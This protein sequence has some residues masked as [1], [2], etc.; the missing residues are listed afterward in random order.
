MPSDGHKEGKE[1]EREERPNKEGSPKGRKR[2]SNY[3]PGIIEDNLDVNVLGGSNDLGQ[4]S[5]PGGEEGPHGAEFLFR[6]KRE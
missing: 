3:S 1:E 6:V 4:V 2:L 5:L